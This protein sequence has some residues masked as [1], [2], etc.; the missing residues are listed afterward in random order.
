MSD[1]DDKRDSEDAAPAEGSDDKAAAGGERM[2]LPKWN[3]ARVKRKQVKGEE[4]D[5]F[6]AGVRKAGREA[7]SR[8]PVVIGLIIVVA[9]IIAGI[10]WFRGEQAED[11]A[12]ATR[13]LAAAAAADVRGRV[14]ANTDTPPKKLPPPNPVFADEGAQA[15]QV[16]QTLAQLQAEL[17]DTEAN[18]AAELMRASR[19]MRDGKFADAKGLYEAFLAANADHPLRFLAYE[20]LAYALEGQGDLDGAVA[21]LD[22]LA[23]ETGAFYRDQA[24][25]QKGRLLEAKGDADGALTTYK[26]YLE[27]FPLDQDSIAR[28]GVLERLE[29]LA[30]DLVPAEAKAAAALG[31][32][33]LPPNMLGG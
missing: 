3:R 22:A 28:D 25:F 9:G 31:G 12:K 21:Q 6:Q 30:P 8:A 10:V 19:L 27:E 13:V 17:G 18:T 4:Q 2:D 29:E 15:Q 11:R 1:E 16:E 23:P 14:D 20:G 26:T 32:M 33:G 7:L 5:S 24:L